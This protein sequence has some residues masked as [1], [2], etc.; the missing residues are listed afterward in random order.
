MIIPDVSACGIYA[1]FDSDELVYIGKSNCIVYRIATHLK[2][3]TKRFD[4]CEAF[5]VSVDETKLTS[6]ETHLIEEYKPKYN[7]QNSKGSAKKMLPSKEAYKRSIK[8][9]IDY[10]L[11]DLDR[12]EHGQKIRCIDCGYYFKNVSICK[13]LIGKNKILYESKCAVHGVKAPNDNDCCSWGVPMEE[14][15]VYTD[16]IRE[17]ARGKEE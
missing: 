15:Y 8:R 16:M 12:S 7:V 11:Y 17:S 2:S 5:P 10:Y 13:Q 1:L 4:G 6:L 3:G 14:M 9:C